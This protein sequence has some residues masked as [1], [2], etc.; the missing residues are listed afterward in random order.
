[1]GVKVTVAGKSIDPRN[2]NEVF[3]VVAPIVKAGIEEKSLAERHDMLID[4][5]VNSYALYILLGG[6]VAERKAIGIEDEVLGEVTQ[7]L[8]AALGV[9]SLTEVAP[10]LI[11]TGG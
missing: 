9:T 10:G 2:S 1:M 6:L 3:D 11:I 8:G 7:L 4:L 5:S